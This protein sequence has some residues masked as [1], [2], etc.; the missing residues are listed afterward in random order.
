MIKSLTDATSELVIR[1]IY[2]A[3]VHTHLKYGLIFWGGNTKSENIF[4]L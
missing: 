3:Y 4:K 2:F 1:S